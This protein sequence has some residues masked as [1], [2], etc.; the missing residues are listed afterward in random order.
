MRHTEESKR[1]FHM[2]PAKVRELCDRSGLTV[3]YP[4]LIKDCRVESPAKTET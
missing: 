3:G 1:N 4:H 2:V